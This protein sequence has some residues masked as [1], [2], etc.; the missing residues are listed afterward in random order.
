VAWTS[1]WARWRWA[2]ATAALLAL[3]GTVGW[4][5]TGNL[6][7]GPPAAPELLA[8]PT[9]LPVP[10]ATSR[11]TARAEPTVTPAALAVT[12]TPV[13]V[14]IEAIRVDA[15]VTVKGLRADGV[16]DVPDGP[17]D[18]AWYNFTARPGMGGNAV[19][20]GHLD[21]RNYGRAVFWRLEELRDGDVVEVRLEDGSVL[22]YRVSLKV[23]YDARTAPV[24][25]ILGPTIKEVVTLI[26][27]GGTFDSGSRNYSHRLVVR[28]E[29]I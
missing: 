10:R 6:G 2:L 5:L 28:A 11:P 12:A 14:L 7:G 24:P 18:V 20:S 16:M 1:G 22:R 17:E 23:S 25:D 9:A 26:T 27:C 3:A 15:P 8:A 4:V 21:Y 13:R 19:L 29:R